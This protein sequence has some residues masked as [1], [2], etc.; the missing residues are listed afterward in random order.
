MFFIIL[1]DDTH[2]QKPGNNR[3]PVLRCQMQAEAAAASVASTSQERRRDEVHHRRPTVP[4]DKGHHRRPTLAC[5][6]QQ[7]TPPHTQSTRTQNI[8]Q[9][10][11]VHTTAATPLKHTQAHTHTD[12]TSTRAQSAPRQRNRKKKKTP[13]P[14]SPQRTEHGHPLVPTGSDNECHRKPH[15]TAKREEVPQPVA[16]A[17]W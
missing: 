3:S 11:G 1:S 12:D 16:D 15:C 5:A 10:G 14:R 2:T 6:W 9:T 4:G 8:H 7:A 13:T 17:W